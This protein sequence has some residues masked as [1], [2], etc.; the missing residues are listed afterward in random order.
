MAKEVRS[1]RQ[2]ILG[3]YVGFLSRLG[4]SVSSEVRIMF[5]TAV[6]DIRSVTGGNCFRMEQEFG[7]NPSQVT[8]KNF[9]SQYSYYHLPDQ[10]EW[11]LSY[12]LDL[13]KNKYD[14]KACDD[15]TS[16]VD[17]LIESLCST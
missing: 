8:A 9:N 11:R 14:M 12:L 2:Q 7:F 10:E 3:L 4:R 13:L 5:I 15:D 6:Q 16:I 17:T 1:A